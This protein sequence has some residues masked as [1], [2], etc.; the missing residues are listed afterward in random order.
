[1]RTSR[2]PRPLALAAAVLLGCGPEVLPPRAPAPDPR[3]LAVAE[4]PRG[5]PE[6]DQPAS[7]TPASASRTYSL[8]WSTPTWPWN[9]GVHVGPERQV[10]VLASRKLMVHEARFGETVAEREVCYT[11]PGA[12]G[13]VDDRT[14]ALVC[15]KGIDLFTLPG[16]S[17]GG[18]RALSGEARAA[19]FAPGFVAVAFASGAV[20]VLSTQ[21]WAEVASVPVAEPIRSLALSPDGRRLAIGLDAGTVR[22]AGVGGDLA[23][24]AFQM[25]ACGGCSPL[26]E[27]VT[28]LAFSPDSQLLFASAA[29]LSGLWRASDGT[30]LGSFR[31]VRGVRDARWLSGDEI[32]TVGQDGALVLRRDQGS[33]RSVSG[34]NDG[35]LSLAIGLG[36]SKDRRLLCTA[37]QEGRVTCFARGGAVAP[38]IDMSIPDPATRGEDGPDTVQMPGRVVAFSGK[39]MRVKAVTAGVLPPAGASVKLLKYARVKVGPLL[40]S[41]WWEA[42][43][44]RVTAVDKG[45]VKLSIVSRKDVPVDGDGT[46]PFPYDAPVKLAWVERVPSPA[47][48]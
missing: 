24:R 5:A 6:P 37:E 23:P 20:Q 15:E 33:V 30:G 11:F 8:L 16:L 25:R 13:F 42:G 10:V 7:A 39:L 40:K 35:D 9:K 19:A 48:K 28:V 12:L 34:G 41:G 18:V 27:P 3:E 4:P 1:M 26:D 47:P 36:V 45:I 14:L 38:R 22:V 43:E 29:P 21:T 46:D 2:S 31:P 17:Y 44:A 32:A